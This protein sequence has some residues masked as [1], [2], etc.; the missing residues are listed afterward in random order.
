VCHA[1]EA[2]LR[3][4]YVPVVTERATAQAAHTWLAVLSHVA[5]ATHFQI[6]PY[7]YMVSEKWLEPFLSGFEPRAIEWLGLAQYGS[8]S[9]HKWFRAKL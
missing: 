6:K 8:G 4:F 1:P 7:P 5:H 2:Y 3:P 9:A